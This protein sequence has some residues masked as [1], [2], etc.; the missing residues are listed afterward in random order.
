MFSDSRD[1]WAVRRTGSCGP[2]ESGERSWGNFSTCCPSDKKKYVDVHNNSGCSDSGDP[3]ATAINQCANSTLNLWQDS[4]GYF[5]CDQDLFGFYVTSS[6]WKG[7][8]SMGEIEGND[9][10]HEAIKLEG[11]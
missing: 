5:C 1:G 7:C 8:A 11:K 3:P 10:L 9:T 4:D 2:D 6:H